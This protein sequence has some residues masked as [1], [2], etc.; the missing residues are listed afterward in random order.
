MAVDRKHELLILNRAQF[1]YHISTY[2]YC[3]FAAE[4][5]R[6]TYVGFDTG[7]LKL[8]LKD[9]KA[10]YVA[11]AGRKCLRY[12]RLLVAF[13]QEVRRCQGAIFIM[14]FPGCSVLRCLGPRTRMILDIR[15]GSVNRN[16]LV[17]RWENR[18][19]QWECRLFRNVSVISQSL[20]ERL[21]LPSARTHILPLGAERVAVRAKRFARLDLL[22]VGTLDGR[23]IEDTVVG[24]DRFLQDY[25]ALIP[26]TYTIVGDSHNGQLETLRRM[27]CQKGLDRVVRL[28]GYVHKTRL[29]DEFDRCNVGVSYVPMND[30]YDCQPVT[31]TFEYIVAGMPVIATATT[32]NRKVV[33]SFNGVLIPDTPEGF[34]H[35]LKEFYSRRH[36]FDSEVVRRS[37]PESLWDRIVSLNLV[38]YIQDICKS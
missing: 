24:F 5:L 12:L 22:Y 17:R 16:P 18:V 28:P 9:V 10:K 20:A 15:T 11:Y 14:Y 36:E 2:Y 27:V 29:Q 33:K 30:I 4:H 37:C 1:G 25:G 8:C 13:A 7:R 21:C 34:Y 32:E 31:K 23:C 38:P 19:M 35:G 3:K 6:I 26:L